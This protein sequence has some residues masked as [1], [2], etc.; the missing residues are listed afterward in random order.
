M[1]PINLW[2]KDHRMYFGW[3]LVALVMLMIVV[4]MIYL[5]CYTIYWT[6]IFAKMYI[7]RYRNDKE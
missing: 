4:N 3:G 5:M 1:L 7:D 6:A 2:T